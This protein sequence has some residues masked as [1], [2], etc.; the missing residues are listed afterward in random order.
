MGLVPPCFHTPL[1]VEKVA[2]TA[3]DWRVY[4]SLVFESCLLHGFVVLPAGVIINFASVPR[5]LW[6]LLPPTGFYDFGTALHDG[7]Y[8]AQLVTLAGH[9]MHLIRELCDKLLL[10]ACEATG[11]C[12][13][14]RWLL[15]H[16][17]RVGG[18]SSYHGLGDAAELDEACYAH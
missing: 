11:V 1:R 16:G 7:S 12:E 2:G 15:Y 3:R 5:G 14:E 18:G 9:P 13:H 6:N 17:V 10:E 8:R 4:E